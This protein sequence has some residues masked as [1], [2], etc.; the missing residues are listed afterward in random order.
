MMVFMRGWALAS[1][2]IALLANCSGDRWQP[3]PAA[4]TKLSDRM[5]AAT[6][7]FLGAPCSH[8]E[9]LREFEVMI[10]S[11]PIECYRFG[12]PERM[13]GIWLYEFEA[14]QFV[15]GQTSPPVAW[16]WKPNIVNLDF[17]RPLKAMPQISIMAQRRAFYIEFIGRRM[18]YPFKNRKGNE[19]IVTV[20]GVSR[21]REVKAPA[22]TMW[23]DPKCRPFDEAMQA[24]RKPNR[25]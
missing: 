23:C 8:K 9:R 18:I 22:E 16:E 14:S 21:L 12:P 19:T 17:T 24:M 2:T 7:G 10:Q 15:E 13:R 20:D 11:P 6:G 5:K 1:G 3:P 4:Y 25:Q